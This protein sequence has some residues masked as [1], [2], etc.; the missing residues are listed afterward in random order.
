MEAFNVRTITARCRAFSRLVSVVFG[1]AWVDKVFGESLYLYFFYV[2]KFI[3]NIII[4]RTY[5]NLVKKVIQGRNIAGDEV[6]ERG[7]ILLF[8]TKLHSICCVLQ[9]FRN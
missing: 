3:L 5:R 4:T 9:Y 6:V 7:H 1:L 8:A 2:S